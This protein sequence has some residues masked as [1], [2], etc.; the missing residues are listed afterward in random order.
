MVES[1]FIALSATLGVIVA[2]RY[3]RQLL[4]FPLGAV[5]LMAAAFLVYMAY[6]TMSR[7]GS[8]VPTN[9]Y[10]TLSPEAQAIIDK[11]S[12]KPEPKKPYQSFHFIDNSGDHWASPE[13]VKTWREK[14][15]KLGNATPSSTP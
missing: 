2:A 5:I 3:C 10:T 15:I 6:W 11:A 12:G 4:I 8:S 13:L 14:L 9:R 7:N 1:F